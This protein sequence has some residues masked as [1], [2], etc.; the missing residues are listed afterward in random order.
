MGDYH[1]VSRYEMD[2]V[3]SI[4]V[5]KKSKMEL[6]MR[7]R[8]EK[9]KFCGV[10]DAGHSHWNHRLYSKMGVSEKV[11]S[12]LEDLI[13][14]SK[15]RQNPQNLHMCRKTGKRMGKRIGKYWK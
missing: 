13:A 12:S 10:A 7:I 4:E 14:M 15:F 3:N 5:A 6:L 2:N 8:Y 9:K 1:L 11:G